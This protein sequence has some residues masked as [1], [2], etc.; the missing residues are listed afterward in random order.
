MA[1]I[2]IW[3]NDHLDTLDVEQALQAVSVQRRM[4]ALRYRYDKDRRQSLAVYLLLCEGLEKEYGIT[5]L[6][7]FVFGHHGKPMLKDYPDIHFNLSHCREAALCVISD[8]PVG[9]DVESV[10]NELD[11]DVCRYCYNEEEIADIV[12]SDHPTIAFTIL[13]TKKEAY[14]KLTGEGLTDDL[15]SLFGPAQSEEVSF[16]TFVAPDKSYVY[17]ICTK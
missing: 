5:A 1:K 8:Q 2:A 10:P 16:S 4:E 12:A 14:L 3:L 11:M 17:T 9:C 15:P 7:Q 6:P 13:W